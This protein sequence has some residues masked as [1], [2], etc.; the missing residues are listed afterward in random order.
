MIS[1]GRPPRSSASARRIAR[2]VLPVAVAPATT[3]S[4]GARRRRRHGSRRARRAA[5]TG[6]RA[7]SGPRPR[8]RRAPGRRPGGRA[9]SSR[10][11]P[12]E[13]TPMRRRHAAARCARSVPRRGRGPGRR[14]PRPRGPRPRGRATPRCA[15][16]PIPSWSASSAFSRRRLS[17]GGHVVR[18]ARRGRARARRVGRGE[19]L[20]VADVSSRRQR[21]LE[22]GLG[23]AAEPDDDVGR[24]GDARDGRADPAPGARGSARSCTGGPSG[25]GPRRR[26][27]GP[28]GGGAR[29]PTGSRPGPR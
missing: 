15:R 29:R 28:A 24:D 11:R 7:R 3:M 2:P 25:A 19:D 1:T 9:C 20:V 5:R 13:S 4:G 18:E 12:A 26:R 27:T 8:A 21:R 10:V 14:G 23:L 17:A 6:R 22:L 16:S